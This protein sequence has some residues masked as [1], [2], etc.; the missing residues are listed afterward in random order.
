MSL[1]AWPRGISSEEIRIILDEPGVGQID[2]FRMDFKPRFAI[3]RT[4]SEENLIRSIHAAIWILSDWEIESV[5]FLPIDGDPNGIRVT[6]RRKGPDEFEVKQSGLSV[7]ALR[8][9]LAIIPAITIIYSIHAVTRL[10]TKVVDS[11]PEAA[12]KIASGFQLGALALV[13]GAGFLIYRSVTA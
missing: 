5:A 2:R 3:F 4:I 10:G 11:G 13:L 12:G 1:I 9:A 7:G 8:V 6:V